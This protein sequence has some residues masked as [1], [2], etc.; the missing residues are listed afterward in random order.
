MV[1]FA[2]A[3]CAGRAALHAGG[4]QPAGGARLQRRGPAPAR[5]QRPSASLRSSRC[6]SCCTAR[7]ARWTTPAHAI[8][9]LAGQ[10]PEAA[11]RRRPD[12]RLPRR[13]HARHRAL[14][15]ACEAQRPFRAG[16]GRGLRRPAGRA[17]CC[18]GMQARWP[19]AAAAHGI[20]GP[21]MADARLRRP[22]GRTRSWRCAAT[23][24]CCATTARSSASATS[25]KSALLARAAR[26]LHRRRCARFQPGPG[27]RRCKA[28]GIKT[29]HFVCPSIW[30]WRP[31]RVE[32]IRA[33][34]RPCAVHLPLRAGAAGPTRHRRQLRRPSAGQRDPDGARPGRRARARSAWTRRRRR[35]VAL[36]PGSRRSEVRLHGRALLP[37]RRADAAGAA[38][39]SASSARAAR[40][41]DAR[42]RGGGS[43]AAAGRA[44]CTIA[45]RPVARRAGGLR[46]DADRQRHRHAGGGAVQAAHGDR[47][48]H[49]L[50][51]LPHHAAASSC[52]PGSA[53]PTSCAA[54]SSCPNCC[55]TTANP[56]VARCGTL[57]MAATLLP[58]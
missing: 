38:R 47:L 26:R 39:P 10:T 53:C 49:E 58:E 37:G 1:G 25:C 50:A 45:R 27:S 29:V 41:C 33:R 23:S 15:S 24:R 36:L 18:D 40:R 16:R 31:E 34:C 5:L 46:R 7:A 3:V 48:Q 35:C 21:R 54:S 55:R 43:Q 8:A 19:G 30:A 11:R 44:A 2:S 42:G 28:R 52:S 22:G 20:G 4:R 9:A 13:R 56:A 32:K 12:E 6:T 14:T 17:C 51:D 57:G